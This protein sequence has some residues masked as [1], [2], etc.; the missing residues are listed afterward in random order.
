MYDN[1]MKDTITLGL[2]KLLETR[3]LSGAILDIFKEKSF[4]FL[5]M[6]EIKDYCTKNASCYM[7]P[8][9]MKHLDRETR[10]KSLDCTIDPSSAVSTTPQPMVLNETENSEY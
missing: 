9:M 3:D 10:N 2:Y 5:P 4:D 7:D 6:Y 8:F 1:S